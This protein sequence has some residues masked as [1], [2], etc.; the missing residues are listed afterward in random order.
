MASR[1]LSR[2]TDVYSWV[3][4]V[5]ARRQRG[6]TQAGHH[7]G[8]LLVGE[9]VEL[10]RELKLARERIP[11][12]TVVSEVLGAQ[13]AAVTRPCLRLRQARERST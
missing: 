6:F 4:I 8:L 2:A 12:A 13:P 7:S 1:T 10:D 11:A 5:S 9:A 3:I